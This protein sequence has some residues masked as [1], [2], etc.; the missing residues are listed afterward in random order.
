MKNNISKKIIKSTI[1][2]LKLKVS[3]QTEQLLEQVFNFG[4][5]GVISTII[6]F[7]FLYLFKEIFN[8]PIILSNTLSFIISVLYNYWASLTFVFNVN[9]EKDK[10]KNFILF[11]IFSLIG[12]LISNLIIWLIT[13]ILKIY[14]MI[15]KVIATIIVMI[16]NFITR[17]K[18]LE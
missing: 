14:Y 15:S 16:F 1:K 13:D 18:F 6:D 5:V 9:K 12:L 17:K 10:K 11:I 7:I 3:N 8:F 2:I 4:I